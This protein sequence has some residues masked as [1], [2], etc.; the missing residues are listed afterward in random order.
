[1][2]LRVGLLAYPMFVVITQLSRPSAV[3]AFEKAE[4]FTPETSRRPSSLNVPMK[5]MRRGQKKKLL[6]PVGD[7]RYYL[8]RA[9]LKRAD[10]RSM[11]ILV[12]ALLGFL[13]LAWLMLQ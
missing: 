13:P 2:P 12:L 1:M 7:G 8:D 10:R 11:F 5:A 3:P 4:A 6:V 9:A